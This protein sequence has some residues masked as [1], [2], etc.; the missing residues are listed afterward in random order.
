MVC[1]FSLLDRTGLMKVF[2]KSKKS[3]VENNYSKHQYYIIDITYIV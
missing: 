2:H 3:R 1:N